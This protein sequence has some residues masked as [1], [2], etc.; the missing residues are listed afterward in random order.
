MLVSLVLWSPGLAWVLQYKYIFR[1]R[2]ALTFI[3]PPRQL[4]SVTSSH[5]CSP[6]TV[7]Y[8]PGFVAGSQVDD[9]QRSCDQ[10]QPSVKFFWKNCHLTSPTNDFLYDNATVTM[11]GCPHSTLFS[12]SLCLKKSDSTECDKF[13]KQAQILTEL[14]ALSSSLNKPSNL[15]LLVSP[16]VKLK[17]NNLLLVSLARG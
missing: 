17:Q 14:F 6:R 12:P 3:L 15:L 5:C 1:S 10:E 8:E 4:V 9:H 7:T 11:S 13:L 16:V 2:V